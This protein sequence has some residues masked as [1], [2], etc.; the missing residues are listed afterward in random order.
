MSETFYMYNASGNRAVASALKKFAQEPLERVT[1][2]KAVRRMMK[3]LA[4]LGYTEV[5][6]TEPRD[7]ITHWVSKNICEPRKWLPLDK[8]DL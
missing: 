2:E 1:L 5:Y 7:E 3:G 4:D 6:D 8:W